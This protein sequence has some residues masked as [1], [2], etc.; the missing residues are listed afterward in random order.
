MLIGEDD[1]HGLL[2]N[3]VEK[4]IAIAID[5]E[6]IGQGQRHL[7]TGGMGDGRRLHEGL[8]G[9]WRIPQ[10][11]FEIGDGGGLH[12]RLIHIIAGEILAGTE[13]GVHGALAIGRHQ[14]EA[15]R[16]GG[17]ILGGGGGEMHAHGANVV[18]EG[19]AR[20]VSAHLA[21]EGRF[22][23]EGGEAHNGV[24]RR[25][26]GDHRARAHGLIEAE[27][28]RLVDQ[29]HAALVE[30]FAAEKIIFRAGDHIHDRIAQAQNVILPVGH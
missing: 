28:A 22:G 26:A 7:A 12:G 27:G 2:A 11:A 17:A 29:H 24:G 19:V 5:A 4:L 3:E 15:A 16:G 18:G 8:L 1:I 30:V 20:I 23:A 21:D 9:R 14:H 25:T 13:I 6:G 10:I